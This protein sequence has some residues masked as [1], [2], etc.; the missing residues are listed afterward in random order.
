MM[1]LL[2]LLLVGLASSYLT[3]LLKD[4]DGPFGVVDKVRGYLIHKSPGLFAGL[5]DCVWCLGTWVAFFVAIVYVFA[6]GLE[7]YVFPFLWL[8]AI[9]IVVAVYRVLID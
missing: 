1:Y 4:L 6:V 9:P 8:A 3:I 7:L 5:F 2:S